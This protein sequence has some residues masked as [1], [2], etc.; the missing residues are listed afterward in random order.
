[1]KLHGTITALDRYDELL[2]EIEVVSDEPMRRDPPF[3]H[4]KIIGTIIT[5]GPFYQ[6]FV[7]FWQEHPLK[8]ELFDGHSHLCVTSIRAEPDPNHRNAYLYRKGTFISVI[9]E[10]PFPESFDE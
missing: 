2:A 4:R 7:R 3:V 10:S 8:P 6:E 1:M 5:E 9:L